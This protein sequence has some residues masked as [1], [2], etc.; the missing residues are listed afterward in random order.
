M[1]GFAFCPKFFGRLV[2]TNKCHLLFCKCR[3]VVLLLGGGGYTSTLN[4]VIE[5]G[6]NFITLTPALAPLGVR[7]ARG[8][9]G[10]SHLMKLS[11]PDFLYYFEC[12]GLFQHSPK[13]NPMDFHKYIGHCLTVL[14]KNLTLDIPCL[15]SRGF[16]QSFVSPENS[17]VL[18]LGVTKL[19]LDLIGVL[20][21]VFCFLIGVLNPEVETTVSDGVVK[22]PFPQLSNSREKK[23]DFDNYLI[24]TNCKKWKHEILQ[25]TSSC[26]TI[27]WYQF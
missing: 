18:L 23:N 5:V 10:T 15:S 8:V 11:P 21:G 16:L 27:G 26:K 13:L 12:I 20:N 6:S 19:V 22:T 17:T 7:G 3:W 14:C 25:Q 24:A 4:A 2:E 1:A 9:K